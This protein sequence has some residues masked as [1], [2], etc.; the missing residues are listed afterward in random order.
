M[1]PYY[2][3][4]LSS[5]ALKLKLR[6]YNKGTRKG[7]DI[8]AKLKEVLGRQLFEV[9]IQAVV[10]GRGLHSST[11]LAQRKHF[12]WDTLVDAS[13]SMAKTAQVELK[14]ERV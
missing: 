10:G 12:L 1:K 14:R 13:L 5:F 7:R 4:L 9:N 2:D 8:V 3:K 11:F 6:R